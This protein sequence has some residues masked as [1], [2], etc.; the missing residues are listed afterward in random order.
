MSQNRLQL[1]LISHSVQ[2]CFSYMTSYLKGICCNVSA[3]VIII[4][5]VLWVWFP[6]M[7][8]PNCKPSQDSMI[9][10]WKGHQSE[11]KNIL[12][13]FHSICRLTQKSI[14]ND[15]GESN[16]YV[17]TDNAPCWCI[18][19]GERKAFHFLKIFTWKPPQLFNILKG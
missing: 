15:K 6:F 16:F 12:L 13:H 5:E 10:R 9:L 19:Y 2:C 8:L 18:N 7:L 11:C 1:L 3:L 17:T 14:N 4:F